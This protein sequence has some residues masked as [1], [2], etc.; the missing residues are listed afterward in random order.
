MDSES[1][2]ILDQ[3]YIT[4]IIFESIS[5]TRKKMLKKIMKDDMK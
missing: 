1:K 2:L 5:Q 3:M 4:K